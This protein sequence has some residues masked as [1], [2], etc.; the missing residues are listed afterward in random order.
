MVKNCGVF[1]AYTITHCDDIIERGAADG[2]GSKGND[3]EEEG[4]RG[5]E[6]GVGGGGQRKGARC[7][8]AIERGAAVGGAN[9]GADNDDDEGWSGSKGGRRTLGGKLKKRGGGSRGKLKKRGGFDD[10]EDALET[11][12]TRFRRLYHITGGGFFM[13]KNEMVKLNR[14]E[15]L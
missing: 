10:I 11:L 15:R 14:V 13:T 3:G 1:R 8:V 12:L 7:D 2:G 5:S 6:G 9:K 4:G